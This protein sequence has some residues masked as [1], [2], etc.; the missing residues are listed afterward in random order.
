MNDI[1]LD[2]IIVEEIN[3]LTQYEMAKLW[4][5]APD[6]HIYFDATLPYY[7]IFKDRFKELGGFTPEISKQLGWNP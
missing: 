5:F 3:K 4:R 1:I 7:K 2:P 6:G